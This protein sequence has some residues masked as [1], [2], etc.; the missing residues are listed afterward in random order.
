MSYWRGEAFYKAEGHPASEPKVF[1]S[2][3]CHICRFLQLDMSTVSRSAT[4]VSETVEI[5][6]SLSWVAVCSGR[7]TRG[8]TLSLAVSGTT[9]IAPENGAIPQASVPSDAYS[10]EGP[11]P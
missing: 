11:G 5:R 2:L 6:T 8:K 3:L 7:K 9:A 1:A 4:A 10:A